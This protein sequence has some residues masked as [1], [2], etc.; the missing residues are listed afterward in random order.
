MSNPDTE[1]GGLA[2]DRLRSLIERIERLEEEQ[3]A[4]SSDIRDIFAEAKSAGFDVKIMRTIIKL[5]KMNA[6]DRDEQETLLETYRRA[7]DI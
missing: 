1:I 5:R 6:A 7:L 4:L 3:K 2:V